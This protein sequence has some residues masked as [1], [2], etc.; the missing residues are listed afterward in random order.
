MA[1]FDT[2]DEYIESFPAKIRERLEEIRQVILE[3]TPGAGEKISDQI[4]TVTLDERYLIY[5]A[6]WKHHIALYP[7][8]RFEQ[9]LEAEVER[10][11]AAK[12]ALHIPHA[13]PVPHD[14][15]RE[16]VAELVARRGAG[17]G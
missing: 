9:P 3:A 17:H 16:V 7:I 12:D 14:L 8:P 2:V 11:R 4:P 6:A 1:R 5:F 13:K 15:V 10:Y